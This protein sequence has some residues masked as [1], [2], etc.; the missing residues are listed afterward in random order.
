MKRP[1]VLL[2]DDHRMVVEGLKSLLADDFELV[3]TVE[4]GRELLAAANKFKPR[5]YC[6]G[7]H[8]AATERN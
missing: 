1:R 7:Y 4:D 2:A 5:R 6:C 3:D 8:Y